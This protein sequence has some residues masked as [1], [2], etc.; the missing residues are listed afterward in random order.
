MS[1]EW[2]R[3]DFYGPSAQYGQIRCRTPSPSPVRRVKTSPWWKRKPGFTGFMLDFSACVCDL[4]KMGEVS[5]QGP[6]DHHRSSLRRGRQWDGWSARHAK[7]LYGDAIYH[8]VQTLIRLGHNDVDTDIALFAVRA[9]A[10]RNSIAHGAI[11]GPD[12]ALFAVR[13]YARRNFI[14]HGA[15]Y[16][17]DE[18][19]D[20]A[21]SG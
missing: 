1:Y 16:G 8:R 2:L 19:G 7:T 20:C 10:R 18:F 15:I 6:M 17:P 4:L 5:A 14:A 21:L 11:Y 13:T 9:Y 3:C 12:I